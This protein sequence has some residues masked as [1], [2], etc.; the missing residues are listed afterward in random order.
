MNVTELNRRAGELIR[1]SR[2]MQLLLVEGEIANLRLNDGH[3][4]FSLRDE[5]S[6]V[7][8]I[9]FRYAA[10][11][12][13]F[14]PQN[15]MFVLAAASAEL[16]PQR[17]VFML[18]VTD[19]LQQGVGGVRRGFTQKRELLLKE[20][21]LS[22]QKKPIPQDSRKIGLIT[23][24][25]GAALQDMLH[26]LERRAP[27][28]EITLFSVHVQ[29]KHAE[30]DICQALADADKMDFD[31][32]IL[33]RGGGSAEDLEIFNSEIIVR[34]V[35]DCKTPVISAVGHETDFTL[36]DEAADLRASTPSAGAELAS[37]KQY[38]EILSQEQM[39]ITSVRQIH[40][41]DLLRISLPDGVVT[42]RAESEENTHHD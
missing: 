12:L 22:G 21:I 32:L 14:T 20:G 29:G 18:Q 30:S 16:Y 19:M 4:Y 13:R 42:V 17:G 40:A 11:E 35:H 5:Q 25:T 7:K 3:F 34:A 23:S 28:A 26:V 9:M 15:G 2:H 38:P 39:K 10:R 33:A 37:Q 27:S 6:T 31:V 41:G 36:T 24:E 8:A 1:N